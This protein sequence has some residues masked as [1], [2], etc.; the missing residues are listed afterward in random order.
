VIKLDRVNDF[1][2]EAA[3]GDLESWRQVWQLTQAGFDGDA[4]YY[5]L[6]GRGSDGARDPALP[7]LVDVD[8]LIDY[9]LV[10]FYTANLDAPVSKFLQNQ[11]PN[12][13]YAINNRLDSTQGFRFFAHDN[14]HTLLSERVSVTTGVDEDRVNI[15]EPGAAR[16]EAGR[17]NSDYVMNVTEFDRFHP[18]WLHHRLTSNAQYR[19]RFAARAR[20]LL[21]SGGLL[22]Q[23]PATA[24]FQARADE[25]ETAIIAESARWGD[26]RPSNADDPRTK[27]DDWLPAIARVVDGFFPRRTQIV[28]DQLTQARLY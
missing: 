17:P 4:N 28:I 19:A 27:N 6:E 10:I 11:R 1:R 15:G 9:M 12:N 5:A 18:Q 21:G 22:T 2:I 24:L 7:V 13:L 8:N 3:D 16:D 26:A 23:G 25:L 20:Q 14:E